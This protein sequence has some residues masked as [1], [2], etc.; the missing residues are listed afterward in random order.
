MDPETQETNDALVSSLADD[1]D[2]ADLVRMYLDRLPEEELQLQQAFARRDFCELERHAH[3]IGEASFYGFP[4]IGL[5][6]HELETSI[7]H[8]ADSRQIARQ[9]DGVVALCRRAQRAVS[10]MPS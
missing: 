5:A 3:L 7:R 9:V 10:D 2:M 1:P 8:H 4:M 6:A